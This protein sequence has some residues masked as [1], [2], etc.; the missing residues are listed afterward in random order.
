MAS[1]RL[2]SSMVGHSIRR[3]GK[4]STGRGVLT[5]LTFARFCQD[6]APAA[7]ARGFGHALARVSSRRAQ[8]SRGGPAGGR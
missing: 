7:Q 6:Y 1:R 5:S 8:A 3:P 4:D 2:E